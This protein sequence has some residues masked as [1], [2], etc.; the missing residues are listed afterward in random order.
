MSDPDGHI[1][2]DSIVPPRA[3]W[4]A[5]ME[6]GEML[7]II[8]LEGQ[9]AVDFLCFNAD[10]PTERYHAPNTIKA[11]KQIFIGEG[12]ILRSNLARPMMTVTH[13]SCGGHD[14]IFGCCSF[15]IDM[16]RY[17]KTNPECCQRNFERECARHS[18]GRELI[19]P[20]VNF[21]MNVPIGPDGAAQI[22]DSQSMPGDYVDLRA[23]MPVIAV[24]S[25]CPEELNDATGT[26]GPTPIQVIR[27]RP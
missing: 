12:S 2:E 15:E 16:V 9:Q 23:E 26:N 7:R 11:P 22:T 4:S 25:N 14:T 13:D 18:I 24:L 21:F 5:R 1:I 8:D 6:A 17:G 10:D 19:M 3:P 27:W 20:N